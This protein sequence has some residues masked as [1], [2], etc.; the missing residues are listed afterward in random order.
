MKRWLSS[1]LILLLVLMMAMPALAEDEAQYATTK[2]FI[3]VLE[4]NDLKYTYSGINSDDDEK[5]VV[6]FD[7]DPYEECKFR[8][9]FNEEQDLVSI[10]MF[11]LVTVT[12]GETFTLKTVNDLNCDYKHVK[13]V[14]DDS[15]STI[16]LKMDLPLYG[17][18]TGE[19]VY[20]MMS[21]AIQILTQENVE[22]ALL[23]LK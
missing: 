17:S 19:A 12:A 1:A 5:V 2:D 7:P 15:D 14:F 22:S 13:F 18:S 6:S 21:R 3:R 20:D 11:Y 23:S 10:R 9:Y 16:S 4:E 8:F